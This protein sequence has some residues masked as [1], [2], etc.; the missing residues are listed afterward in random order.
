MKTEYKV[1]IRISGNNA[2]KKHAKKLTNYLENNLKNEAKIIIQSII[3]DNYNFNISIEGNEIF[4]KRKFW[5]KYPNY[6]TILNK[7]RKFLEQKEVYAAIKASYDW[8]NELF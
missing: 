7:I 3:I 6:S 5:N 4:A 2:S 8:H 1:L